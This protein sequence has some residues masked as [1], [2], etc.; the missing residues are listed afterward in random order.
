MFYISF[1]LPFFLQL[2]LAELN[3]LRERAKANVDELKQDG[4]L[5]IEGAEPKGPKF[6]DFHFK[7]VQ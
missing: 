1:S 7:F 3:D 5:Y 2:N 4:K 6:T